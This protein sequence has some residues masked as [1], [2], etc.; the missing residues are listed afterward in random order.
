MIIINPLSY[1]CWL[2]KNSVEILV[3]SLF[4]NIVI[5]PF[6]MHETLQFKSLPLRNGFPY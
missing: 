3:G 6:W 2:F 1:A 5:F 4:N